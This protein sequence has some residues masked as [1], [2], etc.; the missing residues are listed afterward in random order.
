MSPCGP[1][2]AKASRRKSL[3]ASGGDR[4]LPDTWHGSAWATKRPREPCLR[5]GKSVLSRSRARR[6]PA[7]PSPRHRSAASLSSF[8]KLSMRGSRPRRSRKKGARLFARLVAS[9][10]AEDRHHRGEVRRD[11]LASPGGFSPR[12]TGPRLGVGIRQ[13]RAGIATRADGAE[14]LLIGS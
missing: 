3:P 10:L 1:R 13:D 2:W 14:Y 8:A 4:P 12:E 5:P 9:E 11:C 7:V 6:Q